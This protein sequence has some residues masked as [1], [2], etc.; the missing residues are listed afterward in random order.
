LLLDFLDF[1]FD[2]VQSIK[3]SHSVVSVFIDVSRVEGF[4]GS[5]DVVSDSPYEGEDES[6]QK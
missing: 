1:F 6:K 5:T 2:V 4:P 3:D